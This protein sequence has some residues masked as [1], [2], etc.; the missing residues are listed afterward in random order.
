MT[1]ASWPA[2]S[3]VQCESG[4]IASN[5]IALRC[6]N[7]MSTLSR[8][9]LIFETTIAL[10]SKVAEDAYDTA[11]SSKCCCCDEKNYEGRQ[12]V[13]RGV[14]RRRPAVIRGVQHR[15]CIFSC[16]DRRTVNKRI[17]AVFPNHVVHRCCSMFTMEEFLA[18]AV[19]RPFCT[20]AEGNI[21]I[22]A[23]ERTCRC[24]S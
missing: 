3:A 14:Q 18:H 13:I 4:L 24:T 12:A 7:Y 21:A 19:S 10:S 22:F 15:L 17:C 1:P 16:V 5:Q 2:R 11:N 23:A 9:L 8:Q 6:A 20:D